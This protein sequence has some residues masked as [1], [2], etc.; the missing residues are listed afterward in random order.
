MQP[1]HLV[2]L[3]DQDRPA[4]NLPGL[5][6][7]A[8]STAVSRGEES[9]RPPQ[10]QFL[11]LPQKTGA[12]FSGRFVWETGLSFQTHGGRSSTAFPRGGGST[13]RGVE[14]VGLVGGGTAGGAPAGLQ[15]IRG[16]GGNG[17]GSDRASVSL[18]V[19]VVAFAVSAA[20]AVDGAEILVV[21]DVAK[22]HILASGG[23]I[24][25][26]EHVHGRVQPLP[27]PCL[28]VIAPVGADGAQVLLI[29][30]VNLQEGD[31]GGEQQTRA[32]DESA[33]YANTQQHH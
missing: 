15:V 30:V 9:R 19:S 17:C 6:T 18:V 23:A 11:H 10:P 2:L 25:Q 1:L 32:Y 5:T 13:E 24:C 21:A 3:L 12:L 20:G 16:T 8:A 14:G 7:A 31:G 22:T 4:Y 29:T 26:S 27:S 28:P 33:Y